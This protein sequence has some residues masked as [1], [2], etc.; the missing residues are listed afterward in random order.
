VQ[1]SQIAPRDFM[2]AMMGDFVPSSLEFLT[3]PPNRA[4]DWAKEIVTEVKGSKDGRTFTYR[5]GTLTLKGALP[6]GVVPARGA[7]W[8]AEGRVAPGVHPP[9]LAFDPVPFLE[10]LEARQIR[11]LVTKTSD[12]VE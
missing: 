5:L 8:Q 12:L 7:V 10:Q 6:T 3:A 2:I 4:P 1:G 11:T 9:E